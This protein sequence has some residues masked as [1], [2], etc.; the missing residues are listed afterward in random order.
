MKKIHPVV[1]GKGLLLMAQRPNYCPV[2]VNEV[3]TFLDL[4]AVTASEQWRTSVEGCQVRG[5]YSCIV[6]VGQWVKNLLLQTGFKKAAVGDQKGW[7]SFRAFS[8]V[9][10]T[11]RNP[12]NQKNP[13]S[14]RSLYLH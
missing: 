2:S 9:A 4:Q 1:T 11:P 14:P 3:V 8:Q 5:L 7:D 6:L 12:T 13:K 10:A